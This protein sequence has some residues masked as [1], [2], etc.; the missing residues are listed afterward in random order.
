LIRNIEML[1]P[2]ATAERGKKEHKAN[3]A[4]LKFKKRG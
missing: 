2:E 1:T 3:W 4:W